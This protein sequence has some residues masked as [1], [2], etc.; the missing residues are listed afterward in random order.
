[1]INKE[2]NAENWNFHKT[3]QCIM[4]LKQES[5]L[6]DE[7]NSDLTTTLYLDDESTYDQMDKE[8]MKFEKNDLLKVCKSSKYEL[9]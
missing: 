8:S 5:V 2:R 4:G 7:P 6:E 1:M 3:T 9:D